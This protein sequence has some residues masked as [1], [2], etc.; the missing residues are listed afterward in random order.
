MLLFLLQPRMHWTSTGFDII[1]YSVYS[2][3]Q[4]CHKKG[5]CH[6]L[7]GVIIGQGEPTDSFLKFLMPLLL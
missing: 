1:W 5:H 7:I 6:Q 4:P 2:L 3:I